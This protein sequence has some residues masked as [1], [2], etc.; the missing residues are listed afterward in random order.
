[1]SITII[2]T[3]SLEMSCDILSSCRK[4]YITYSKIIEG[5]RNC[6]HFQNSPTNKMYFFLTVGSVLFLASSVPL[7]S[8]K[9]SLFFFF[10]WLNDGSSETVSD[11]CS[12]RRFLFLSC[13]FTGI[14]SLVSSSFSTMVSSTSFSRD[15]FPVISTSA[16]FCLFFFLNCSFHHLENT[17]LKTQPANTSKSVVLYAPL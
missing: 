14:T 11:T 13:F 7:E 2:V 8:S 17:S 6:T 9:V 15:A 5:T 16:L 10:G 3:C 12:F 1:M 4:W